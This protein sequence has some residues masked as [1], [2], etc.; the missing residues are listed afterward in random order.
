M[1]E[2]A[3]GHST[4]GEAPFFRHPRNPQ[5][6]RDSYRKSLSDSYYRVAR[7][8]GRGFSESCATKWP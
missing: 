6:R 7:Q 8:S 1:G 5:N 2:H 4:K 3:E